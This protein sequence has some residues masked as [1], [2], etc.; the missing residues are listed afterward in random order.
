MTWYPAP[1]VTGCNW[2]TTLY[3]CQGQPN[4]KLSVSMLLWFYHDFKDRSHKTGTPN[5]K[6]RALRLFPLA[7]LLR[8]L[9]G[10]GVSPSPTHTRVLSVPTSI[11]AAASA[12]SEATHPASHQPL[13]PQLGSHLYPG[14]WVLQVQTDPTGSTVSRNSLENILSHSITCPWEQTSTLQ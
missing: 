14:G 10:A 9:W 2:D 13:R 8:Q 3:S 7:H 11:T 4:P 1:P 5:P 12:R 6:E